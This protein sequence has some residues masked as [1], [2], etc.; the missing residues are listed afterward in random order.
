MPKKAN[1][2]KRPSYRKPHP[3]SAIAAARLR[4][5][6]RRRECKQGHFRNGHGSFSWTTS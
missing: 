5:E 6:V 1:R 4:K 2:F 3:S